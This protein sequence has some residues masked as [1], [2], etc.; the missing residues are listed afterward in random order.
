M[1]KYSRWQPKPQMATFLSKMRG[2]RGCWIYPGT[3]DTG[4][5]KSVKHNGKKIGAHRVAYMVGA[6]KIPKGK[7]VCHHCD[8]PA[9]VRPSHLFVG[10]AKDNYLDAKA[11]RRHTHGDKCWRVRLTER[12]VKYIKRSKKTQTEL[13]RQFGV[14]NTTI[15][16]IIHGRNWKHV[17]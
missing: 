14:R 3:I 17:A 8:T 13:G 12:A 10:S 9:C 4:G 1:T 5:Y 15:W 11:K 6:G 16:Q 2:K 7:Y